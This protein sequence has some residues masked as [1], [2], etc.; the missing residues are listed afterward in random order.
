MIDV[1]A[2]DKG[3]DPSIVIGAIEDAYL[4][5]SRKVFKGDEDLR[6]RF[7]LE[8][9][10]VELYAVRSDRRRRHER[11]RARSR[12]SEAQ[13][14][15]G[16]EAEV[17]MEIEF[18]KE[19]E[20]LGRIAAQTAKQ[21]IAQRV[22]EAE[23]EKIHG[24]FGERIGEVVTATVKRFESGDIIAEIGRVECQ[25]PRKEQ[26]RAE[27][28]AIGDRVRAVIK[29]VTRNAKGPQV[30]L[31]R[32]DPALLVKLF[33]QEVPEIYDG[34][35]MIR[36]CVRE[37]GD[38]AKVA[39]FSRE[40]DVD[41][42][43]A[44]VGM[45][46]TRVQA[47]I[48][49]LRGEK[50]DI[51]EWSEDPVPF[52]TK[53][54]S[55]ARVQRVSIVD[56]EARVMEVVVEDRQLS[57]AIG[58]KGQNVR[59]A[60]KLTGWK[61]DIKSDEDKKK[62]VELQL[63]GIDFGSGA[64][65]RKRRVLTL[66]DIHEEVLAVLRAGGFDTVEKVLEATP[67]A[68]AGAAR[69]RPGHDRRRG[70]RRARGTGARRPAQ[71]RAETGREPRTGG[72]GRTVPNQSEPVEL[73]A[74]LAT[75]RIYKV[76]ELL[77]L[78]S[79]E[80][81]DLLKKETGID[82]KSASSSIEEIVARQFVERQARKRN[83]SLPHGP[84]FAE[85][86]VAKKPAG[87]AGK[88]PE[89]PK[90]AAPV[91]RPRLIKTI[92][93]APPRPPPTRSR[94]DEAGVEAHAEPRGRRAPSRTPRRSSSRSRRAG[95]APARAASR[96]RAGE[97]P[98]RRPSVEA[99]PPAPV[100]ASAGA[101]GGTA[102]RAG[103]RRRACPAR[104]VP[105]TRRLRIEDPLTGEAPAARPV[106]HAPGHSPAAGAARADA[107]GG[108]AARGPH[109]AARRRCRRRRGR[110]W[111]VRGRCR[112]SP[113]GRRRRRRRVRR[114]QQRVRAPASSGRRVRGPAARA[115]ATIGRRCRRRRS[116]CRPSPNSSRWPRA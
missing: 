63:E 45:R 8:T 27:N 79:Q 42:V 49:E 38:R 2:K 83:I 103:P 91:L 30:V 15:Y 44:C 36:G 67:D 96:R 86:P 70:R 35:V 18:P 24:E 73:G 78:S 47:I 95:T 87:K 100:A 1:V 90:P 68:V 48:R 98:S 71:P 66:P 22:R 51:V 105:P 99:P 52:V 59:L 39:V 108:A 5:A 32:T 112:R 56:D 116:R 25:I 50:I 93:P 19:T 114:I 111:A 107:P 40:R 31:S 80:A 110:R 81:I 75:V 26:S 16:E 88:A 102:A 12:S 53:A 29:A 10:Q 46:G 14:L 4:A 13:E 11:R 62:E 74:H 55:P 82:V 6:T 115:A 76:A 54:L 41:P 97:P 61:I 64:E 33:E 28:Y 65:P 69:L 89:P 20:K 3:I 72:A 7:N 57:L 92:K 37:A 94:R 58:K 34:T 9:G 109:R 113:C 21:V 106:P 23:R 17:G 60:A 85:T 84:L 104:I 77:G 43:G 101:S